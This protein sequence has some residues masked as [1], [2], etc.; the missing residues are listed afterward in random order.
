MKGDMTDDSSAGIYTVT[1]PAV[2]PGNYSLTWSRTQIWELAGAAC[3]GA[4]F[5]LQNETLVSGGQAT[6]RLDVGKYQ[7]RAKTST[8]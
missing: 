8:E 3:S 7:K 6:L 1:V 2:A 5:G 4:F